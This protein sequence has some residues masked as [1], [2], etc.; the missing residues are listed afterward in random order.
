M[1]RWLGCCLQSESGR[2]KKVVV[3]LRVA[4]PEERLVCSRSIL[5]LEAAARTLSTLT[6]SL[7]EHKGAPSSSLHSS[8]QCSGDTNECSISKCD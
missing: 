6:Q 5:N 7:R 1:E 4:W 3:G 2:L 8:I